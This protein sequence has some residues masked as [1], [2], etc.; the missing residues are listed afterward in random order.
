M[1]IENCLHTEPTQRWDAN[2]LLLVI[3]EDFA[4]EIQKAW[5][6]YSQRKR[7]NAIKDGLVK[8]QSL[9]RG[10]V[11]KRR[12]TIDKSKIRNHSILKIQSVFRGFLQRRKYKRK[13]D[14]LMKCQA[15][16]LARQQKRAYA[17]LKQEATVAQAYIKRFL[18]MT[19]YK[20]VQN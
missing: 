7:F 6:G 17:R 1:L 8:I 12:Y 10:Y 18:A 13:R 16:V 3:Q 20:R 5:R 11:Q 2:F 19:W 4:I 15:N 14:A 9:A